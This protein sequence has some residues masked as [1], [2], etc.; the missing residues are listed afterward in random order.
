MRL[1][2]EMGLSITG[3]TF[4][5]LLFLP[6][7]FWMRIRPAG[8]SMD[9]EDKRLQYCE[10][11]G[12]LFCGLFL[13]FRRGTDPTPWRPW[14]AWWVAAVACM[15]LYVL[16]WVL[17]LRSPRAQRDYYARPL[18]LAESVLPT[19]AL[20]LLAVYSQTIMPLVTAAIYGIGR[21]GLQWGHWRELREA[22]E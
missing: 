13:A 19:A 2:N 6:E 9:G 1:A 8:Y 18:P 3:L 17:Y 4:L 21:I 12:W 5:A 16:W 7:C 15:A 14:C 11:L 20:T 10:R 22:A